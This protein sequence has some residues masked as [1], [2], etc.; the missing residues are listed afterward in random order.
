MVVKAVDEKEHL[1]LYWGIDNMKE[2][3]SSFKIWNDPTKVNLLLFCL[4]DEIEIVI[5]CRPNKIDYFLSK[6]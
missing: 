1:A 4:F 2:N 3:Q 5:I 6:L